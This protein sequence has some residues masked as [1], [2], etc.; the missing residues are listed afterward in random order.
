MEYTSETN[1]DESVLAIKG[2]LNIE[3]ALELKAMAHGQH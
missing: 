2:E 3:H 1:N